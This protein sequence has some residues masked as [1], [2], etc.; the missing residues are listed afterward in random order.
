MLL[1][2]FVTGAT[3]GLVTAQAPPPNPPPQAQA[4]PSYPPAE[5][6]KLV[7]RIALY[8]D[9]LLA[10][11]LAAA[12]YPD[13]IPDAAKW[14][15]EHHYLTGDNLARAI[16]EDR[17]PWDASVQA[18]LPFPSV[19]EMMASDMNWTAELGNAFLAQQ[20]DVMDAVQRERKKARDYGYLRTNAQVVVAGGPYVTIMPVNPA[21]I[22]VPVWDPLIVFYPPRPGFFIG[23][24]IGFGFGISLGFA[25]TPWGW[26]PSTHFFWDRHELFI[27]GAHWGRNWNN[28]GSYVHPY[29]GFQRYTGARGAE[30][31]QTIRRSE[32]ERNAARQGHARVEEHHVERGG[33]R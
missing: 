9:P 13:Q 11:V 17:L 29:H 27:A 33:R 12:T 26:G 25:F 3:P 23:G 4:P 18:L 21:F 7:T 31:H 22:C 15:D 28:R 19:L 6:D 2:A 32:A 1:L 8:P 14:A 20:Q 30:Q 10:Q 5:L 24:A 16:A